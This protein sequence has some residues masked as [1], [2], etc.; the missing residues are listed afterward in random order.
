MSTGTDPTRTVRLRPLTYLPEGDGVVVGCRETDSYAVLPPDGAALLQLLSQVS[1]QEA[2]EWYAEHYG[3]PVDVDDFLATVAELGFVADGHAAR[4]AEGLRGQRLGRLLFSPVS[5]VGAAALVVVAVLVVARDNAL[6]PRTDHVFFSDYLLLIELTV[7]FGQIPLILV[8]ELF[9]LLAA[10][11]VG[12]PARIR[13]GQRMY[14]VVF[15]TVMDGL[16]A[17]PRRQRYLPMLAG[18]LA[19]LLLVCL[20]T[21]L[22]A[23]SGGSGPV[24]GV[25]LALAFSTLIRF[26]LEFLL[27][28]RTDV[29]YLICTLTGTIDLHTTSNQIIANRVVAAAPPR[30]PDPRPGTLAPA[31]RPSGSLVHPRPRP[32]LR[33]RHRPAPHRAAAHLVAV[34]DYRGRPAG[35]PAPHL[36]AVLGLPGAPT[37]HHLPTSRRRPDLAARSGRATPSHPTQ[38]CEDPVTTT[39]LWLDG[40]DALRSWSAGSPLPTLGVLEG[41]RR[42][43]GAYTA[44]GALMR[45]VVP[46]L[47]RTDPTLVQC[48]DIEVLTAAPELVGRVE[49]RRTTL[50]SEADPATRTRYYPHNRMAWIGN[51]LTD[52]TLE[53]ARQR[54]PGQ[55]LLVTEADHLDATDSTWLAGLLRR[56]EPGSLRIVVATGGDPVGRPAGHRTRAARRTAYGDRAT[57]RGTAPRA[58]TG[59]RCLR[60]RA[61][62]VARPV[63]G[64]RLRGAPGRDSCPAAR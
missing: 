28:L 19:D 56:A 36:A 43:R 1:P 37:A 32:G 49:N 33:P 53:V 11:R 8:H 46:G 7:A 27:F 13:V 30:G 29:Y 38:P 26:A 57:R 14:F 51:G 58:R 64:G 55:T 23:L 31:R 54:G 17:V 39:H 24:A 9:H 18:M 41:H 21:V 60:P 44:A 61:L 42:R 47:L 3:E 63:A 25:C 15:E 45:R 5:A 6:L 16:V 50:T 10:R 12:V 4:P 34:R 35:G 2:A 62:P 48:Y 22:A 20:L 40:D 52:L 59:S